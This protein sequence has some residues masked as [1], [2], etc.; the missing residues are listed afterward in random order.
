MS[1]A[2]GSGGSTRQFYT[3]NQVGYLNHVGLMNFLG[4]GLP[5][6]GISAGTL[7]PVFFPPPVSREYWNYANAKLSQE[8]LDASFPFID[9]KWVADITL[10]DQVF[11]VSDK[12]V[13]VQ[14]S[15]GVPRFYEA[16]ATKAPTISVTTGEWLNPNFEIGDLR[17]ELNNRDGFF[18]SLLANGEEFTQWLYSK[19]EIRVGFGEKASNYFLLFTGF[20]APK[21]G[22]SVSDT[23]ITIKC[24]DKFDIDEVPLPALYFQE[25]NSPY[26]QESVNG[27]GI[28]I[29]Y[30]DWS[31]EVDDAGDIPAYCLN[32][33]ED[34]ALFYDFKV[35]S[36]ALSE[37]TEVYLHRGDRTSDTVD[38]A[39]KFDFS[40][41]TVDL[42]KGEFR[43]PA[44]S[45]VL[46][47][48]VTVMDRVTAGSGSG[49]NLVGA[50]S[51]SM[52]FISKGV[53]AGD[54]I[55]K[56]KTSERA[57]II[58]VASNQLT[59]SGG[60]SFTPGDEYG[61]RTQNF[62]YRKGDKFSVKCKGK[63]VQLMSI[64]RL[65]DSGLG[66][67]LPE[68]LSVALNT[69]FW[70]YDNTA[71]KIY[72]VSQHNEVIQTIDYATIDAAITELSGISIQT[73]N[74]LWIYDKPQ[75][76]FYRWLLDSNSV[77][78]TFLDSEVPGLPS[79]TDGRGLTIDTGNLL[80]IVDNTSG[81]FFVINPFTP[82]NPTLITSWNRSLFD[83]SAVDIS[84][85]SVDVNLNHLIVVDRAT[86]KK[87][88]IQKSNGNPVSSELLSGILPAGFICT[89]VSSSQD[90]TIFL[91]NQADKS[92]YN[93][94][95][96]TNSYRNPGFIAR[97]IIQGMTGKTSADFHL[98]WNQ[99]SRV[100]SQGS[101]YHCRAYISDKTTAITYCNKMLQQFNTQLYIRFGQYALFQITFDNF[102]TGGLPIR[103]GDIK[104]NTFKASKEYSQY[105]NSAYADYSWSPLNSKV[106]RSDTYVSLSGIESAGK[107]I[108]RKFDMPN[109]YRRTDVDSLLPLFVRLAAPEPEF[110]TF[111]TPFR[112]LF[113]QNFDFYN[114]RFTE[115]LNPVTGQRRGGRRFDNI[116]IFIRQIEY[117]LMTFTLRLKFWS[118]GTT[119]F[120]SYVPAGGVVAGGEQDEV[121]LTSLGQLGRIS[122]IG[123]I[124]GSGAD[125]ITI[126]DVNGDD[127]ETREIPPAG[128]AWQGGYKVA[129]VNAVTE[130]VVETAEILSISGN[131][132]TF[133]QNLVNPILNSAMNDA[134]FITSGY[135]L[136][137]ANYE[138]ETENQKK[139]FAHFTLPL[140]GYSPTGSSEIDEQKSGL[141]N[142]PDNR[143]PY[144]L[145]PYN[146]VEA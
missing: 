81:D 99:Q 130:E 101:V 136:R 18:N 71:Q 51:P 91:V 11:R 7:V 82:F 56:T 84:G 105:F 100:F 94:N 28:P 27:K 106:V 46:L 31:T 48:Y 57:T 32:A 104:E 17:L 44:D 69:S 111:E 26:L 66:E 37:L 1:E 3:G 29:V 110:V 138:E 96:D 54:Q 65:A 112:L 145:F 53:K 63:N 13:Y 70:F 124:T 127:A 122:P 143:Q 129:I 39:V 87:Y 42:S 43:I 4:G 131:Q 85:L 103:E 97:D 107:E 36:N 76:R 92:F 116:P 47:E 86:Q 88:R 108:S 35:S 23:S 21:Q 25:T 41:I 93:Y 89:G 133:T 20:I 38:G 77:G 49:V 9:L 135:Y 144:I 14:N 8:L 68:S 83:S 78:K 90:G 142:F 115:M 128:L 10:G 123:T 141:H 59:L 67:S 64:N 113:A 75:H 50:D 126:A 95:E 73:D 15:E 79:I 19:V 102:T 125:F 118:L 33:Y 146:Y 132:I 16:R 55:Y 137:Y 2:C 58:G 12:N 60:I 119:A 6:S 74:T 5:G 62:T 114:L 61:I 121:V 45:P 24:Y 72:N 22:V 139:T 117:D 40:F 30:G 109:V 34:G 98:S 120:G 134:G 80:Y 52:N 140:V